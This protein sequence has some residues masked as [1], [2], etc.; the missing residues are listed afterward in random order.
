[1]ASQP[2]SLVCPVCSSRATDPVTEQNQQFL[3]CKTCFH[4]SRHD[5]QP[6]P[7]QNRYL[8][9]TYTAPR[10]AD[11]YR[12]LKPALKEVFHV[13]EL[14]C[15]DGSFAAYLKAMQ[16]SIK[17]YEGLEVS[18]NAVDAEGRLER[19]YRSWQEMEALSE[20]YD[21]IIAS[22]VLEHLEDPNH[23]LALFKQLMEPNGWLF[24]EVPNRSGHPWVDMDLNPGH[25]HMFNTASL[26]RL[27]AQH[28]FEV[29]H[30]ASNAWESVRYP[31]SLRVLAQLYQRPMLR[32]DRWQPRLPEGIESLVIWGAGGMTR[33]LIL[34]HLR[35]FH[36]KAVIDRDPS[37]QGSSL[38]GIPVYAPEILRSL[39]PTAVLIASLDYEAEIE[40]ELRGHFD[41]D[42]TA[43]IKLSDILRE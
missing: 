17:R 34:P 35:A 36:I 26:S 8:A 30:I 25:F 16:P 39:G 14:G 13:F 27:L 29:V 40:A 7:Y 15:A 12:F 32:P 1:M 6:L 18:P 33:E 28:G 21:L 41:Q 11:Q 4:L 37:K 38:D 3:F 22:H 19:V 23:C 24:I 31:D 20:G 42:V 10:L 43:L 5:W 2:I 9:P